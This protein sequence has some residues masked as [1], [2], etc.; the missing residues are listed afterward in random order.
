MLRGI[1]FDHYNNTCVEG[2]CVQV[3][4][5]LIKDVKGAVPVG[6]RGWRPPQAGAA[7][8]PRKF[9]PDLLGEQ[10]CVHGSGYEDWMGGDSVSIGPLSS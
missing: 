9:W 1:Q 6:V 7:A 10:N 2:T 8:R 3:V 5:D 4:Q